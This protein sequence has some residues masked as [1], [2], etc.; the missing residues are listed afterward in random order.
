VLLGSTTTNSATC[1]SEFVTNS[2]GFSID[3]IMAGWY[4]TASIEAMAIGRPV[5]CFIRESYRAPLKTCPKCE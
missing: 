4:G 2:M 5:I 3:Q 1:Y